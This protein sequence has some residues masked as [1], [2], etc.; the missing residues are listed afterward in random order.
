MAF[1]DEEDVDRWRRVLGTVKAWC[2]TGG[3]LGLGCGALDLWVWTL[4]LE[5]PLGWCGAEIR[6]DP[7]LEARGTG[8][9]VWFRGFMCWAAFL[10]FTS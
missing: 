9:K 5:R 4:K 6:Q 8:F 7:G 2:L 3:S 1:E 10:K